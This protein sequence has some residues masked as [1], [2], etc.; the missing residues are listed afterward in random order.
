VN[1]VLSIPSDCDLPLKCQLIYVAPSR[2]QE[3][4]NRPDPFASWMSVYFLYC[5][6]HQ[7][8]WSNWLWRPIRYDRR[9]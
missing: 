6:V 2:P 9:V 7:Y 1:I 8:Q 3:L 5:F 4:Q